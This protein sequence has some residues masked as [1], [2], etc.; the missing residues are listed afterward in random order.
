MIGKDWQG[1]GKSG[2]VGQIII[3]EGGRGVHCIPFRFIGIWY[4]DFQ[5]V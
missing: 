4:A 5:I 1:T 3:D 2:M